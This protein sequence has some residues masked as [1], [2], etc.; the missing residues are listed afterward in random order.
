MTSQFTNYQSFWN[1][2]AS[3]VTGAMIAVDGSA[4]EATLQAT[5]RY[6]GRQVL[7][8]L[9]VDASDRVLELGCGV[10]RIGSHVAP[11]CAHWHGVDIAPRMIEVAGERLAALP[12][13]RVR[14]DALDR[15]RLAPCADGAYDKAYCVAV[16]IHMDKEDFLIYLRELFRV[17]RPGGRLYFD[18]WN[19]G[20]PVGFRRFEAEVAQYVDFDHS[21]RKDVARNQFTCPQEVALFV[22]AAGFELALLEEGA[23]FLQAVAVKPG[24][25]P[26]DAVGARLRDD[27]AAIRYSPAWTHWFASLFPMFYGEEHPADLLARM[28]AADSDEE[29]AM[30]HLWVRAIWRNNPDR[31]G[32]APD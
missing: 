15:T 6:T 1:D 10:G 28:P 17:L 24:G 8:A 27:I 23:P 2:K 26:A 31:W 9:E 13:G 3:T 25:E 12:A 19:L 29:S 21:V 4:D 5:G 32:P 20:H 18:H 30:H 22:R 16:F 11:A 7:R 14:L